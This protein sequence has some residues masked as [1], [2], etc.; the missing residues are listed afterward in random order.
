MVPSEGFVV[1]TVV[2]AFVTHNA[3]Q[4]V[5][6]L[7]ENPTEA[8]PL[9]VRHLGRVFARIAAWVEHRAG[10]VDGNKLGEHRYPC[11]FP[12]L[13]F[14]RLFRIGQLHFLWQVLGVRLDSLF[15]KLYVFTECLPV[16]IRLC[17]AQQTFLPVDCMDQPAFV[18][19]IVVYLFALE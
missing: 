12:D 15:Q 19:F 14:R 13:A 16:L 7:I 4:L 3:Q 11:R 2:A 1:S 9:C 17:L 10:Q 6:V 8:E 5:P 18:A